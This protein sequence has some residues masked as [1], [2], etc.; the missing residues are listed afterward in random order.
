M[1]SPIKK[2]ALRTLQWVGYA[3]VLLVFVGGPMYIGFHVGRAVGHGDGYIE[4]MTSATFLTKSQV[5]R[6]TNEIP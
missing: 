5:D 2:F 3:V 6:I 4:C 1:T